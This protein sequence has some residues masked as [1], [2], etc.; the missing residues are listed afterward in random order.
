MKKLFLIM[1]LCAGCTTTKVNKPQPTKQYKI[2]PILKNGTS[3][4]PVIVKY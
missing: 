1:A 4:K 3:G 2:T